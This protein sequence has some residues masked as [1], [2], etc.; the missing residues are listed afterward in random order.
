MCGTPL[1]YIENVLGLPSFRT[2]IE[3]RIVRSDEYSDLT[4]KCYK[5]STK[6]EKAMSIIDET[7]KMNETKIFPNK[8]MRF[9][10]A[11]LH[12]FLGGQ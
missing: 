5:L 4:N 10:I 6:I 11:Q 8:D 7:D 3:Y 1:H 9:L 2:P 12:A